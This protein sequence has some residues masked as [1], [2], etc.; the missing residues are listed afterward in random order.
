MKSLA[1]CIPSSRISTDAGDLLFYGRDETRQW[2]PRPSAIVFPET[3]EEVQSLV[4]WARC[5]HRALVPSGGRT[6]LSGGAVAANDEVVVSMHRLNRLIDISPGEPSITVQAGMTTQRLQEL[7][8][9]HGYFYPVDFASRGSSQVGGN[10]ATNAGG[11]RVLRYG[12]TRD[13][14]SGIT[15]VTGAGDV[16]ELNKG[17]IKNATGY[18]LRHLMVGSEGTLGIVVEATMRLTKPPM[19]QQVAVFAVPALEAIA[20]IFQQLS[21]RLELSAFEFFDQRAFDYVVAAGERR[22]FESSAAYYVLAEFDEATDAASSAF[23]DL[24]SKGLVVDGVLSQSAS[25]ASALW[26]LRES[27]SATLAPYSPYKCDIAVRRSDVVGF[28]KD[29]QGQMSSTFPCVD[30]VWFGH[31]G[32]GNLHLNV[33]RP[34][35]MAPARFADICVRF[36]ES[37]CEVLWAHGGTV[38]AEHGVGILKK[39]FLHR[40]RSNIEIEYMRAIK[41]S[42]DPDGILNPGKIFDLSSDSESVATAIPSV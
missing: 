15:V 3:L 6:G 7:A 38:S 9:E 19:E 31:V 35:A 41:Q 1:E 21:G 29:L 14:V 27:V 25:Q 8:R 42:F 22:P 39:P 40:T 30:L 36:T 10:I 17:L 13:W 18:D 12:M 32:D 20:E 11:I 37:M 33:L 34:A 24:H 2:N 4:R 28:M 5:S 26:R 16:L 23:G